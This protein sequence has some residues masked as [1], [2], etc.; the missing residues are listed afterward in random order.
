MKQKGRETKQNQFF[1]TRA[2]ERK[3]AYVALTII[4]AFQLCAVSDGGSLRQITETR[5]PFATLFSLK[6]DSE[7]RRISWANSYRASFLCFFD[8]ERKR[9]RD[10]EN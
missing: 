7:F 2:T 1:K 8:I 4:I 6:K 3:F 5:R 9:E 10:I